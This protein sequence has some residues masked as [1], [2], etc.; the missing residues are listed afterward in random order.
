MKNEPRSALSASSVWDPKRCPIPIR[1]QALYS[2]LPPGLHLV[3]RHLAKHN[4]YLLLQF[5]AHLCSTVASVFYTWFPAGIKLK[6]KHIF[7][8]PSTPGRK[9]TPSCCCLLR[10]WCKML[11]ENVYRCFISVILKGLLASA[12]RSSRFVFIAEELLSLC[13]R[14]SDLRVKTR[15]TEALPRGMPIRLSLRPTLTSG[16]TIHHAFDKMAA[17]QGALMLTHITDVSW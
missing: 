2:R 9:I 6:S 4:M 3:H 12:K 15:L 7:S 10:K 17:A 8:F 14:V 13:S 16:E 11:Q 5:R 1:P